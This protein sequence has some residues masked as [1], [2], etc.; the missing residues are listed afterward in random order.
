MKVNKLI[1]FIIILAVAC[2]ASA[3]WLLRKQP[4]KVVSNMEIVKAVPL[5]VI[6]FCYFG[7]ADILNETVNN[8]A[9]GW[10][11]FV[12]LDEPMLKI[13][14][15]M[16]DKASRDNTASEV[17]Q[18]QMLYSVHPQGKNGVAS[19][20]SIALPS[21]VSSVQLEN[22]LK[23]IGHSVNVQ[24][25]HGAY[26]TT[27][28][29]SDL[30][31]HVSYVNNVALFSPSLILLQNAIR[32]INSETSLNDND[33][34]RQVIAS[35]GSY[36]EVRF[37]ISHKALNTLMQAKGSEKWKK[38]S[39]TLPHLA[40][41]TVLDGQASPNIIHLNGFTF[42][43]F[44][45]SNYLSLLLAQNG[46]ETSAWSVLP[47]ETSIILN[48]GLEDASGY[49]NGYEKFLEQRKL[50]TSYKRNIAEVDERIQR[51]TKE[52]FL[53]FYP[54]EIA[55]AYILGSQKSWVTMFKTANYKYVLE[56]LKNLS[57]EL[58]L[59]FAV[60]DKAENNLYHNP[61]SGMLPALFGNVYSGTNDTYFTIQNNWIVFGDDL[62]LL[63]AITTQSA[64]LKKYLQST[65]AAQYLSS[66]SLFSAYLIPSAENNEEL[67]SY[68]HPSVQENFAQA[69]KGETFKMACLQMRASGNKLYTAFL[70][71]YDAEEKAIERTVTTN[72]NAGQATQIQNIPVVVEEPKV[73]ETQVQ[74]GEVKDVRKIFTVI[75][76][77]NKQKEFLT[78]YADHSIALTDKEGKTLWSQKIGS[79]ILDTLY[80]IDFY[81][82]GKLQMLFITADNKIHLVDRKGKEVAPYPLSLTS[83]AK[84]LSVFDYD[85]NREYRVFVSF[86]NNV[87]R[88]YDKKGRAV[89]GWNPYTT[90]SAIT[91]APLFVRAGGRDY[92]VVCDE[93]TTYLLD[94]RGNIRV[95]L[96]SEVAVKP[97]TP[98]VIQQQPP[99]LKVT[100]TADKKVTISLKD[101]K[102]N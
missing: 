38:Y 18:S 27:F 32:H 83:G 58:K 86:A 13:L 25:Y 56:Q 93:Q 81:K 79:A 69:L 72:K 55:S 26:I 22:L 98:I 14:R 4:Q 43:S 65:Q 8:P 47:A 20:F 34:F 82:N 88:L 80:Q 7:R 78:Q 73:V 75:N 85:K 6:Y 15:N 12:S 16:Q 24:A 95:N 61:V 31:L 52:L 28:G 62:A 37:F 67:L 99:A 23:T 36:S 40:D 48:L 102:V 2:L 68:L 94:R 90:K 92:I 41:W 29:E 60:S 54:E 96:L 74:S 30:L 64:S 46:A 42:P 17:L 70:S 63:T 5:D 66:S 97:G 10:S 89:D 77:T 91:R 76:H 100:T 35:S 59:P 49:L 3:F 39:T 1:V 101:G 71:M 11:S 53:S 21:T 9:S 33:V 19:L 51:S 57:D 44:S 45:D 87:V 84:H 50:S